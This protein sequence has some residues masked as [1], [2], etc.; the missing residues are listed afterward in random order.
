M[1]IQKN[2]SRSNKNFNFEQRMQEV[3]LS[4][5]QLGEFLGVSQATVSRIISGKTKKLE[6]HQLHRLI[7][8]MNFSGADEAVQYLQPSKY[9]SAHELRNELVKLLKKDQETP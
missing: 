5:E 4:Q 7:V 9:R 3:G 1:D 6:P 2:D 8:A